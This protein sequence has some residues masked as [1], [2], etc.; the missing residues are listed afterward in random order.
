[1]PAR[2]QGAGAGGRVSLGIPE[3]AAKD[4]SGVY[5]DIAHADDWDCAVELSHWVPQEVLEAFCDKLCQMGTPDEV[6]ANVNRMA[7]YGVRDLSISGFYSYATPT[8]VGGAFA[9]TP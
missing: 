6:A 2:A 1:L 3:T 9:R 4:V 5:P 8:A 7:A